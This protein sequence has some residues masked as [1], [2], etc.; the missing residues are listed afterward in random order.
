MENEKIGLFFLLDLDMRVG[1][2]SSSFL[3]VNNW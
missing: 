2:K 1:L 3:K